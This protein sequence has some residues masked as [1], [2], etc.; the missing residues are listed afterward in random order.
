MSTM[1]K[2]VVSVCLV[3]GV[4][5]LPI[6]AVAATLPIPENDPFFAAPANLDDLEPGEIIRTR[7][8]Q[9]KLL[10]IPVPA[11]GWQLLYR[12]SD[13][14]GEPTVTATTLLVPNSAAPAGKP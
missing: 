14:T 7:T 12:T 13:R 6:A 5:L 9:P 3:V 11:K 2:V 8:I 1:R 4:Y 10:E